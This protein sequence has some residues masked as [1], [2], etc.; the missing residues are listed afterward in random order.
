ME[1][2][3]SKIEKNGDSRLGWIFGYSHI[4]PS[5]EQSNK[6][7][8]DAYNL[9]SGSFAGDPY[10]IACVADGH[11]DKKYPNSHIGSSY[12]VQNASYVLGQMILLE[13]VSAD[14]FKSKFS[15]RI[16]KMWGDSVSF[17]GE[18]TNS[19]TEGVKP[20][21]TKSYGTTLISALVYK[22]YLY[23]GQIGDGLAVYLD[24][25]NNFEKLIPEAS[26]TLVGGTTDSLCSDN[27][28]NLF[29]INVHDISKGGHLFI[30]TDGLEN[31]FKDDQQSGIWAKDLTKLL[32]EY[33]EEKIAKEL[34]GWLKKYAKCSGDDTTVIIMRIHPALNMKTL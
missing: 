3:K 18:E 5:H 28:V 15:Q 26:E 4:G 21:E 12:A 19:N 1:N 10:L 9:C 14:S 32:K 17:H 25:N 33:G 16:T 34:P 24:E 11:G 2:Q 6:P 8:Q 29:R 7:N 30:F 23:L 13:E 20:N 22:Q 27:S 31:A